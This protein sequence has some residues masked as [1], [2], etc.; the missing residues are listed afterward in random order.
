MN[1][2]NRHKNYTRNHLIPFFFILLNVKSYEIF[3]K[4]NEY[5]FISDFFLL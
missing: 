4:H 3:P 2:D 1:F 5:G